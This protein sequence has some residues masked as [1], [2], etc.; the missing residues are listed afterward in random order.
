MTSWI[1]YKAPQVDEK[2]DRARKQHP[3]GAKALTSF[4]LLA[5]WLKPCPDT[6]PDFSAGWEAVP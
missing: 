1:C 6:K 2:P 3:S 5:A 4:E